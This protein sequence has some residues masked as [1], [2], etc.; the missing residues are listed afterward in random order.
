VDLGFRI[1]VLHLLPQMALFVG[2]FDQE[3][4]HALSSASEYLVFSS[5]ERLKPSVTLCSQSPYRNLSIGVV[6][7]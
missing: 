2:D 7:K 5:M 3:L 1:P 6:R 4:C